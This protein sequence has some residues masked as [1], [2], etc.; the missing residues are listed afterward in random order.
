MAKKKE[1]S[2]GIM[3]KVGPWAFIVGLAIA[4]ATAVFV[5]TSPMLIGF[6]GILGVV[7]GMMNITDA[8][9]KTYLIAAIAFIVSA[10]SLTTVIRG[11]PVVGITMVQYI[12]P[13]VTHIVVFIAPGAAIVA[14][15]ALYSISKD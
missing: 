12:D 8:E 5:K 3:R 9:L 7:V 14:L 2:N 13:F 10:S 15:K 4:I 1:E 11:I 6:L